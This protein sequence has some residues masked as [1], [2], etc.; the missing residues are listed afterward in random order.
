M[1]KVYNEDTL[2]ITTAPLPAATAVDVKDKKD[3]DA[4]DDVVIPD[5]KKDKPKDSPKPDEKPKEDAKPAAEDGKKDDQPGDDESVDPDDFVKDLYGKQYNIDS[6][7]K[8]NNALTTLDSL[9]AENK[10]LKKNSEKPKFQN[11]EQEKLFNFIVDAGYDSSRYAEGMLSYAK[12]M[13]M[14]AEKSDP[15]VILETVFALDHPEL[16]EREVQTKFKKVWDKTYGEL[17]RKDFETDDAFNEAV[18][19]RKIDLK[20]ARAKANKVISEKQ[21]QFKAEPPK[22]DKKEEKNEVVSKSIEKNAKEFGSHLTK[23]NSLTFSPSD[24]KADDY[25]L[26]FKD[27]QLEDIRGVVKSWI[28][29][30]ASYDEKGKLVLDSDPEEMTKRAAYLLFGDEIFA[31]LHEHLSTLADGKRI[32]DLANKKPNRVN[33]VNGSAG[34]ALPSEDEQ[35]QAQIDKKKGKK[36]N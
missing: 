27:D 14:D 36:A 13:S 5:D 30:P 23:F 16:N 4:P 22:T 29:N 12:I 3:D 35:I 8:L 17:D 24:D 6:I 10:E 11:D 18:E 2:E 26:K 20:T 31:K 9:T 28:Q 34:A 19:D 15:R 33:K 32:E 1:A 7:E 21:K 25:Q